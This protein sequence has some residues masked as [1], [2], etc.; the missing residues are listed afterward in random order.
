MPPEPVT[1]LVCPAASARARSPTMEDPS[2]A[3]KF[4]V[5][6]VTGFLGAGKTT[7]VNHILKGHHGKLIAVIENEF[8][9]VPID[10]ALVAENIKEKENIIN[11]DNGCVCCS[12]RMDLVR[13]LLTLKDRKKK[14]DHILIETTGLADP[15][16]VA[17]TFFLNPEIADAYRI[18]SI[19]CLA[20]AKHIALHLEEEKADDAV[21]EAVQQ[22]AFADRI[23]LNKIDLVDE[24]QLATVMDTIK[25][26]NGAAEVRP[27]STRPALLAGRTRVLLK[28]GVFFRAPPRAPRV[29]A[30]SR[31]PPATT[32]RTGSHTTAFAMCT[33]ILKDFST[34]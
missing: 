30:S 6:I 10:D 4:P 31:R 23:L 18:D 25:S 32:G 7:L 33:S 11:M 21:N 22:V 20:D 9:A 24:A 15:A 14:F 12:V 34:D 17:T 8:G 2:D 29:D 13:A 1:D 5:T 19:L 28:E 26:I 3:E 27:L 16:P